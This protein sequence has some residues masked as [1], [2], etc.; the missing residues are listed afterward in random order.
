MLRGSYTQTQALSL[1]RAQAPTMLDVHDRLMALTS[2]LPHALANLLVN[3]AG[4]VTVEVQRLLLMMAERD[5]LD[6]L[7]DL[8]EIYQERLDQETPTLKALAT[9][10]AGEMALQQM[11]EAMVDGRE[12]PEDFGDWPLPDAAPLAAEG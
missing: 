3:H 9:G 1:S 2:H 12:L 8:V 11:L 7:P 4:D 5:R 10:I 6:L